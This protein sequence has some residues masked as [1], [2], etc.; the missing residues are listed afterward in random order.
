M[1]YIDINRSNTHADQLLGSRWAQMWVHMWAHALGTFLV[2]VT[3]SNTYCT[4]SGTILFIM[5][6]QL[7]QGVI[8]PFW[9]CDAVGASAGITWHSWYCQCVPFYL[10]GKGDWNKVLASH[11]TDRIIN[12]MSALLV[13]D[14]QNEMQH[15]FFC[16]FTL[17]AL[18]S[19]LCDANGFFNSTI[20]FI[21]WR[22]LKQCAK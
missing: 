16:H 20:V 14:E 13:Q 2:Y 11:D 5:W 21:M 1:V 15:D 6:R 22:Q 7:K 3:K 12:S 8:L 18:A 17:L 4:I 9:L 19:A 10:L